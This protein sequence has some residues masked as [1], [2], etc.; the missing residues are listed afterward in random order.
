MQKWRSP[1]IFLC[2]FCFSSHNAFFLK[3]NNCR[4][5]WVS[6]AKKLCCWEVGMAV[7]QAEACS[8]P[9][10]SRHHSVLVLIFHFWEIPFNFISLPCLLQGKW[11]VS[12]VPAQG[13]CLCLPL[14]YV[15]VCVS[16]CT[17]VQ[18][19]TLVK[20]FTFELMFGR[21]PPP[22]RAAHL[23]FSSTRQSSWPFLKLWIWAQVSLVLANLMTKTLHS[24]FKDLVLAGV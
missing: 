13:L 2:W 12:H 15:C 23:Y 4:D 1:F 16:V 9:H 7:V 6:W 10:L 19:H 18:V 20:P 11:W 3:E 14:S 5:W 8:W 17:H 21:C 24:G 22:S